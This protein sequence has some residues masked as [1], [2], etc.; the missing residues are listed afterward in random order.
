MAAL[1]DA[2]RR[3]PPNGF[4]LWT[5]ATRLPL[6]RERSPNASQAMAELI[7][8]SASAKWPAQARAVI[9]AQRLV[10]ELTSRGHTSL[11]SSR[12]ALI[13]YVVG[14]I[15]NAEGGSPDQILADALS[16]AKAKL[17][18]E[19]TFDVARLLLTMSQAS[20]V[21]LRRLSDPTSDWAVR[22]SRGALPA[23]LEMRFGSELNLSKLVETLCE[24][25]LPLRLMPPYG[26]LVKSWI[27]RDGSIAF[28]VEG[29]RLALPPWVHAVLLFIGDHASSIP[30][31][32]QRAA[33][34]AVLGALV[35]AGLGIVDVAGGALRSPRSADEMLSI[36]GVAA[37]ATALDDA[38]LENQR[39]LHVLNV[40]R[41]RQAR[42]GW[43]LMTA[44]RHVRAHV[45]FETPHML[46][47]GLT[48]ATVTAMTRAAADAIVAKS[49]GGIVRMA[50][51][52]LAFA[53]QR[54]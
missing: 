50:D 1:L 29:D 33:S 7:V 54:L 46:R 48:A 51:G 20:R 14:L 52:S 40:E 16:D 4:A 21:N 6:G 30:P 43:W 13:A 2:I 15:G 44:L 35:S 47:N 53:G 11:F 32:A 3:T 8:A 10:A 23:R 42:L 45:Y 5:A 9:T 31:S 49:G 19:L 36:P 37:V 28:A 17:V 25:E 38:E 26:K 24:A 39:S 41:F 27:D 34:T 18:Q 12:P 22:K